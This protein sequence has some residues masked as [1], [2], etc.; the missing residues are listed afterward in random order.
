M[1]ALI[2]MGHYQSTTPAVIEI[3][4]G[5]VFVNEQIFQQHSRDIYIQ[6][7]WVR[8]RV[9][10]GKFLVYWMAGKRI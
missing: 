10:Q 8:D 7:Y 5:D 6:F 3:T 2:E 9:R 1:H 4:T